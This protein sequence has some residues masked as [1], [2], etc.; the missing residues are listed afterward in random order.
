[1]IYRRDLYLFCSFFI[2]TEDQTFLFLV[3]FILILRKYNLNE[4]VSGFVEIINTNQVY[5]YRNIVIQN[6]EG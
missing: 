4:S 2:V 6:P 1:M 3:D 5:Y